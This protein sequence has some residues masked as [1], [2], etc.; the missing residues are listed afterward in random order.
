MTPENWNALVDPLPEVAVSQYL[1]LA[2]GCLSVAHDRPLIDRGTPKAGVVFAASS[3]N[4]L[5]DA[6]GC[7]QT[8]ARFLGHQPQ[9][10]VAPEISVRC[11]LD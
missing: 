2:S 5:D 8:V 10:K 1:I 11:H 3:R 6:V 7:V 4:D 9:S